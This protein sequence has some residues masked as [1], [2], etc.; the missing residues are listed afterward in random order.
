M[1]PLSFVLHLASFL[2]LLLHQPHL[3][4]AQRLT[5]GLTLS[6]P[7]YITSPSGEF[8][9]GFRALDSDPSQFLL[10]V[11]FNLNFTQ[12]PDPAQEKVVWYAKNLGS[13]SAVMATELSVFSIGPQLSLT[14]NT[15]SII[16]TNPYPSLQAG[17]ILALQ[18]S[19]NLQLLATGGMPITWESFQHPTDTLLP[20][21]SL[22]SGKALLSRHSD[23]VFFPGRYSLQVQGDGNI[24]LYLTNLATGNLDSHNAY[25]STNTY[26]PDNQVGNMTIFFDSSGHLYYQSNDSTVVDLIP[27]HPKS[28]FGYHQHASLDPDGIFRMYTRPKNAMGRRNLSWAVTGQFPTEGCKIKTSMQGLCGPNSYC[29]YGPNDRLDC[30]CPSGYSYVDSQLRYMGCTQGFMSQS[31]DG[32]NRSAEFGV[33]TLPNTT[34]GNSPYEGYSHTTEDQCADSCLK[35]CLCA[36][37]MYDDS[38]CAKMVSLAGFGRQGGDVAMKALIKVRTSNPFELV[39]PRRILPYVLLGCSGFV[40]LSA[41]SSLMLHWYLRKKNANHDFVRAYT[42]KELYRA[43]NGFCKLLGRGGFGE[44]YHGVLKS[45][46]SPDIAVKKLISSNGYSEREFANEVQSIG[47]IHHRNLVRMVGYCKEQEQRMLVFEFMPGG[48]LRSFLFQPKRPM[49][50]WRA[51]AA[52]GIAKGLEYLHEEC[53]YP[54]I[55]CDIKPDN[56]LLDDKK[57]PKITDFGIAKLLSDQ[58]MHTTVTNIRGTRGYIAPEWF[59]SDRRID[60]K[61][62]VYSFGVV[63]LEM[64]CCRKCQEPVTGLDGDDSVT[65]FWCA[66]QLVCHGKIKVL[67]HND[68]DTIEDLVRVERFMRV[69]LWCIEQNPSLRPTMHQVVQMLEGVVEVDTLPAPKSSNCSSPLTSSVDGSTLLPGGANLEIE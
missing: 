66:G 33:V 61:V 53:N 52:L 45:L 17:S 46:H 34:W 11:W 60:T 47:Q 41:I 10:A 13:G 54:I 69:A 25:W 49:W 31:C 29:V 39:P 63:L 57:N 14:D 58:Q 42:A 38:Y 6:P 35:D 37:A 2:A 21:Q 9:F 36:A 8:A 59:Q 44:V 3:L 50:S 5:T 7:G 4:A 56:I 51:K 55:H 27:P 62:D 16:W 64:I 40:L 28:R 26:Q 15:G 65:L 19:G 18:D 48:S 67:L 32:K 1:K 12:A 43:T 24:V 23:T 22:G 68:D 30:E 20:G